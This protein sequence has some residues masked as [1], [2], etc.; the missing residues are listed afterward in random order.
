[1]AV[2]QSNQLTADQINGI[3]RQMV[4]QQSV[5]MLQ[6]IFS[7]TIVPSAQGVVNIQPRNVGLIRGFYVKVTVQFTAGAVTAIVP[8]DF[9]VANILSQ[10]QFTDLNNNIRIQTP[11]WHLNFINSI[12]SRRQY[13]SSLLTSAMDGNA[14]IAGEYGSNWSVFVQ[15]ASIAGGTS[16][17][18]TVWYYVPL[19][20]T[21]GDYRGA[22]YANV[23]NATM[24]L[25]LTLNP[26]SVVAAGDTTTAVYKGNTGTMDS[27]TITVYQD[28]LDQIPF[29]KTGP[30]LPMTDLG[31]IYELKQTIFTAIVPTNDFPM[32]YAN[33]RQFLS[34]FAVFYNG[35]ARTPGTDVATWA[36][37]SANFTNLWKM[38]PALIALRTRALLGCDFPYG[39]YYFGSRSKPISTTQ[40][41]NMELVLNASTAAAGSYVLLAYEDLAYV[42][43]IT[44]AGSLPSS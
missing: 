38:E 7:Q 22:I 21:D 32:Q 19:A 24:Q 8:T 2:V 35:T 34:T 4:Q 3:A 15:P 26:A 44:Q 30:I 20:Y 25:T 40:Y 13:A 36:L 12:K 14:G 31:T 18:A 11:G 23:V 27:A 17:T 33:F 41:G 29:G 37:Q 5:P 43:N 39:V 42:N 28:Y 9:G 16:D 6:Q 10:I 1:M